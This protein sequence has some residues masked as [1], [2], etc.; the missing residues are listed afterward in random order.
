VREQT[1]IADRQAE[2]CEEPHTEKQADLD[3][4]N[5]AIKQQAQRDQRTEKGQYIEDNEVAPL[6]LVKVAAP[7]YSM[8]AHFEKAI[9]SKTKETKDLTP[10]ACRKP[11]SSMMHGPSASLLMKPSAAKIGDSASVRNPDRP[12]RNHRRRRRAWRVGRGA[13]HCV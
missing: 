1:V 12:N 3:H 10:A 13:S 4:A 6:Q 2:A 5:G 8:I 7:D 11:K 9:D